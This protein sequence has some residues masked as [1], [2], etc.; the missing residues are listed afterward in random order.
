MVVSG[1][2]LFFSL[3][4]LGGFLTLFASKRPNILLAFC[5]SFVW[6][7]IALLMWFSSTP[8]FGLAENWS[9][10]LVWV[11]AMLTFLP[12]LFQMDTEIKNDRPGV[13]WMEWGDKPKTKQI[14]SAEKYES[15]L[16]KRLARARRR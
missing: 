13:S 9:K 7:S 15:E 6:F 3:I 5:A 12:W 10:I 1:D 14:N 2:V 11:F 4:I 8:I 16:K